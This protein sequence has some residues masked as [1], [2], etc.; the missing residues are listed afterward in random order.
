MWAGAKP[1]LC[2]AAFPGFR[3]VP[4]TEHHSVI[5]WMDGQTN[6]EDERQQV[7]M[8]EEKKK[9]SQCFSWTGRDCREKAD[10]PGG[11]GKELVERRGVA[12]VSQ[13]SLPSSS[14][15]PKNYLGN[16]VLYFTEST[17]LA[18]TISEYQKG[19]LEQLSDIVCIE[20]WSWL[21][22]HNCDSCSRTS[23]WIQEKF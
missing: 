5:Y 19:L 18:Q 20:M 22:Y 2:I 15:T 1:A 3:P 4:G 12:D 6:R 8:R 13:T 7:L 11:G 23:L 16:K 21:W 14:Q 9:K 17:F 10:R